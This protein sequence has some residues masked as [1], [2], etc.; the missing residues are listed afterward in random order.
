MLQDTVQ[1]LTMWRG[2]LSWRCDMQGGVFVLVWKAWDTPTGKG[3]RAHDR[4]MS[5]AVVTSGMLDLPD[6]LALQ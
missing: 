1:V 2:L 4:R 6:F 3:A 5:I